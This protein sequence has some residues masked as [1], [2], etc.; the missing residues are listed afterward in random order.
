[1]AKVVHIIGGGLAGCEA[2]W[3]LNSRGIEVVLYEM[4]GPH[5]TSVHKTDQLA[6]LVCSNSFRGGDVTKNAVGVLHTELRKLNSLIMWAADTYKVPAGGALAVDRELFAEAIT[7]VLEN[8]PGVTIVREQI[9]TLPDHPYT[10]IA[11]GPL[12]AT[13]LAEAIRK[14][15]GEDGLA[16]F[17][18]VAPIVT[19][20]SINMDIAWEQ[21]RYDKGDKTDY[22][23]CPM[24][25]EQYMAFITAAQNAEQS[26][27]HNPEDADV[28]YFEGCLPIEVMI[29]RGPE[30]LRFGPLKPV[31]L[32]NPR[33][34]TV[35]PY[36]VVQLRRDNKLGTLYNMVGF[37]TRMKWGAQKEVLKL[38]PGLENAEIV[39]YGVIHKNTFIHSPKVLDAQLRLKAKPNI[40]FAGQVTG[41]EGYVESTAM[42]ALAGLLLA[43]EIYN[44]PLPLPPATTMLG[45]LHAHITGGAE[46]ATFQPMNINYGLLPPLTGKRI[47]K[48]DRKPAYG[49]RAMADF[50]AWLQTSTLF[51]NRAA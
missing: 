6:E 40:R 48:K 23:N 16:F 8:R 42:G 35:K 25:Q 4:R 10:L 26:V 3:Q 36:A 50:D 41:V 27:G 43:S 46:A 15:T 20:E 21:S 47:G 22:I 44:E 2:A 31:G 5:T 17:D 45:A 34:P 28:P 38:I 49:A 18:A 29:D 51:T 37:Q 13:P 39:R 30:T 19:R 11:T 9:T 1:V 14:A 12:T 24:T 33:N 7:R 32:T